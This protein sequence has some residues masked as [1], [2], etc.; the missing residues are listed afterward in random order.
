MGMSQWEGLDGGRGDT[1]LGY[2]DGGDRFAGR[3]YSDIRDSG[4]LDVLAE[5][6]DSP[7]G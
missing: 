1:L 7:Q 5:L 2:I 3:A 4:E 6:L